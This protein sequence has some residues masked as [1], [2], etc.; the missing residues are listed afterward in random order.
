MKQSGSDV[1]VRKEHKTEEPSRKKARSSEAG[2]AISSGDH[3]HD[4]EI[5]NA[6]KTALAAVLESAKRK[7]LAPPS[8]AVPFPLETLPNTESSPLWSIISESYQLTLPELSTLVLLRV[9]EGATSI[10]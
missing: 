8:Q 9:S 6:E 10:L 2:G 4:T 7:L 3:D 1:A 5:E